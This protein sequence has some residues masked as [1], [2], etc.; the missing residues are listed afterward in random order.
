[1][2]PLHHFTTVRCTDRTMARRLLKT[3]ATDGIDILREYHEL[4]FS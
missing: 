1:M 4:L 2:Y 3:R